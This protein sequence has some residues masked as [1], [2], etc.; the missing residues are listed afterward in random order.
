MKRLFCLFFGLVL[1]TGT[2]LVFAEELELELDPDETKS[3]EDLHSTPTSL[4][5][6]AVTQDRRPN[7]DQYVQGYRQLF[8]FSQQEVQGLQAV[9]IPLGQD[10]SSIDTQLQV[11]SQQ[12]DRVKQ[13][14][15]LVQQ[16]I[17]GL[18][19]LD[20]KFTVQEQLLGLEMKGLLKRFEKL[21]IMFFRVKRQFVMED[22]RVNLIQL[23][24]SAPD[25][26]DFLFQDV[27]LKNIQSQLV[28]HM[29]AVYGEQQQLLRL[30]GQ[31][32][33][34]NKQLALYQDRIEQSGQV[35]LQQADFQQ[36]LL[37]DK[38]YEQSFFRLQ[39]DEARKE[40]QLITSRIQ[41]LAQGVDYKQYQGF[42][43]ESLQWPVS[44][45]LGLSAHFHDADYKARFA[46]E[47]NAIDIPTD[48]LT[49]IL[50]PLSGR[51]IKV[52]DGGATGYSYLQLAHRGGFSTGYGHVFSFKVKEGDAVEQGQ[53]IALSGG[54]IG[55]HGA[56]RLT[57]GPHLH[58]ELL[59]HG[60]YTDPLQYLPEISP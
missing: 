33:A 34:V 17:L 28:Q 37:A 12:I 55:T 38:R 19:D 10:L 27:I 32:Q 30:R 52:Q 51:V 54:S 1:L 20:Q 11:L 43:E 31:L 50:A 56:G 35:L 58:F 53:I 26:A 2:P 13:Q 5:L 7:K 9:L 47:H 21:V 25:P 59:K 24:A 40:Q 3:L 23:F 22:G 57:T 44:P 6:P 18:Q 4:S 46:I 41:A 36:K 29:N 42:P 16:K 8:E 15:A 48:Q 60:Q 49:P 39:L 14:Q 45:V